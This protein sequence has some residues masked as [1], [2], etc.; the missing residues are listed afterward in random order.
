MEEQYNYEHTYMYMY[1]LEHHYIWAFISTY[2][3][4][5]Y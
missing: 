1:S 5:V 4:H 3:L 2:K